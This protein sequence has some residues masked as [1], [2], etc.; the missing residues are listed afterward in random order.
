MSLTSFMSFPGDRL[1]FFLSV[2]VYM[3]EVGLGAPFPRSP[4]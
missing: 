1:G 2:S 3:W 4:S